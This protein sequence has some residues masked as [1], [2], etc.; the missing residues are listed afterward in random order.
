MTDKSLITIAG[1]L[2][3][4]FSMAV[5]LAR[6]FEFWNRDRDL[7][8]FIVTDLDVEIP[9]DLKSSSLIK[10]RDG[11]LPQGFGAKLQLD[12]LIP[13]DKCLFVD[14]DCLLMGQMD[15]LF[16]VFEGKPVCVFGDTINRG[17]MFGDVESICRTLNIPWMPRFNGAIYYLERGK[18]STSVFSCARDLER[19]YD[20]IGFVRLRGQPNEEMLIGAAL[21]KHGIMP[22]WN[23]GRYYADFQWWPV[24]RQCDIKTG[25][26][27]M[28]N[29]AAPHPL[30]QSRFP[31]GVATPR[32][33][34]FLGHHVRSTLYRRS[35]LEFR[36]R[37][38]KW[39][40]SG[41][42]A[43]IAFSYLDGW[44]LL[45]RM[46]RPLYHRVFGYRRVKGDRTRL[47]VQ[48]ATRG[49]SPATCDQS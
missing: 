10:V 28:L 45:K 33:I 49:P 17:E 31:A 2:R 15:L 39:P 37:L 20:D 5:N 44:S 27:I 4:Y 40:A 22:V 30:H 19:E 8:L 25:K 21:A 42:L 38:N 18:I 34:H 12:R 9:R 24:I 26:W 47:V 36:L 6:S 1:G 32:V 11:D 35:A 7:R 3:S 46:L 29:P 41:L 14:A 16:Q 48:K 43:S 23:D 13:T